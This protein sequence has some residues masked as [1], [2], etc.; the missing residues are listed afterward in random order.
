SY[1]ISDGRGG[2]ATANVSLTVVPPGAA[3]VSLFNV[4][5]TPAQTNLNDGA[6]LELGMKFTSSVAGQI[7]ALKFYRS[8]SHTGLDVLNLWTATGTLLGSATFTNA[9]ASGWQ[10]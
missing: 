7:T 6:Q 1:T 2:T 5:N 3:P 4:S 10:T 8:D 9:A